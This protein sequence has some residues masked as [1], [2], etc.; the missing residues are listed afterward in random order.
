[1]RL[2]IEGRDEGRPSFGPDFAII[3]EF[4]R[5]RQRD[6]PLKGRL[7]AKS[8]LL[9]LD[10]KASELIPC[11][12]RIHEPIQAGPKHLQKNLILR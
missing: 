1:M 6:K 2:R 12:T 3:L 10:E 4:Q 5:Q 11:V 9:A 7:R 8:S